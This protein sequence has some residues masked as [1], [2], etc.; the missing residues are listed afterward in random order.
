MF[1][2]LSLNE[3]IVANL[4]VAFEKPLYIFIGGILSKACW[5]VL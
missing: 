5:E 1:E 4:H 3:S 2:P